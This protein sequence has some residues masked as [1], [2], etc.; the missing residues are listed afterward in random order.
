MKRIMMSIIC[1]V[2]VALN[3]M[4]FANAKYCIIQEENGVRGISEEKSYD[5]DHPMYVDWSVSGDGFHPLFDE[6]CD[7]IRENYSLEYEWFAVY[8]D[9]Y[10]Y[11]LKHNTESVRDCG[12][13]ELMQVT[14]ADSGEVEFQ[15]AE[16]SFWHYV[17]SWDKP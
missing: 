13:F 7:Y 4:G 11:V 2:L 14:H 1:G 16:D 9:T 8:D 10:V 12:Y 3:V 17:A 6:A 15:Q 5:M